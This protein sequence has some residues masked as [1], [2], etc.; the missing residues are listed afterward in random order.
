MTTATAQTSQP[1]LSTHQR[2]TF[3]IAGPPH[4]LLLGNHQATPGPIPEMP[5]AVCPAGQ[6]SAAAYELRPGD[7]RRGDWRRGNPEFRCQNSVSATGS[8]LHLATQSGHLELNPRTES[9][10]LSEDY[11]RSSKSPLSACRTRPIPAQSGAICRIR[12]QILCSRQIPENEMCGPRSSS[13]RT[14]SA[15]HEISGGRSNAAATRLISTSSP[16]GTT[17]PS[18]GPPTTSDLPTK[19]VTSQTL[20]SAS[21]KKWQPTGAESA[22]C[23]MPFTASFTNHRNHGGG[24]PL[25]SVSSTA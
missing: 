5:V 2:E 17:V 19:S 3:R 6:P 14:F 25:C 20:R 11:Q 10:T 23:T 24:D 1:G 9:G 16:V 18:H 13:E 22:R 12:S 15:C 7:W 21:S 8:R 4:S